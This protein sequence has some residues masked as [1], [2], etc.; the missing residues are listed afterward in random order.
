MTNPTSPSKR[1]H[2][3]LYASSVVGYTTISFLVA[4][5]SPPP[6]RVARLTG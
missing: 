5:L 2:T 4:F 3:W 6:A 1:G